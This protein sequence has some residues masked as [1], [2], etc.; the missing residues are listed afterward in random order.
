MKEYKKEDIILIIERINKMERFIFHYKKE[1]LK[2]PTN[3]EISIFM[4]EPVES[5]IELK[6][7]IKELEKESIELENDKDYFY[8]YTS[9]N[10]IKIKNE[11]EYQELRK[12]MIENKNILEDKEKEILF[13]RFSIETNKNYT[14]FKLSKKYNLPRKMIR[15]ILV[16]G[17]TKI[18]EMEKDTRRTVIKEEK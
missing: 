2:E 4:K 13:E 8:D 1:N 7:M 11:E 15:K 14:L 12:K 18:K 17:L 3:E 9:S 10:E 5:I 16:D 6:N